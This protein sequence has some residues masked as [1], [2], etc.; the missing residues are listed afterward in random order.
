M[1][2][3]ELGGDPLW[4]RAHVLWGATSFVEE[5]VSSTVCS[6]GVFDKP[7]PIPPRPAPFLRRGPPRTRQGGAHNFFTTAPVQ[8][9]RVVC[10]H[11][12][13]NTAKPT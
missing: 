11:F 10:K 12:S 5:I 2:V 13:S 9:V 7:Q 1:C 8:D 6:A 3:V 4:T